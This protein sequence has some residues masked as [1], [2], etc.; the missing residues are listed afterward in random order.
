MDDKG[1]SPSGFECE[2]VEKG[3]FLNLFLLTELIST[4]V[5]MAGFFGLY[6]MH[7][8]CCRQSFSI[9]TLY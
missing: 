9:Y 2:S 5:R 6:K 1:G 8:C 7:Y 4:A 3:I